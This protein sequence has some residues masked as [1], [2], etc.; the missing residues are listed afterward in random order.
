MHSLVVHF[1]VYLTREG[2]SCDCLVVRTLCCGRNNPGHSNIVCFFFFCQF[3]C[4]L[5][6]Y[7]LLCLLHLQVFPGLNLMSEVLKKAGGT[8]IPLSTLVTPLPP[9]LNIQ[10]SSL[11]PQLQLQNSP[12]S[13]LVLHRKPLILAE[14]QDSA[15]QKVASPLYGSV[16]A[17]SVLSKFHSS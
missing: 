11:A 3:C 1:G 10:H 12:S 9:Q 15:Q 2:S 5:Y 8:I 16:N 14:V 7:K 13:Q 17:T 6:N 4:A